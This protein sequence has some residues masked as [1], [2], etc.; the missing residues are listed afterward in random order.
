TL[1][2]PGSL[3]FVKPDRP[4]SLRN[5]LAWWEYRPGADWRHPQG[6]GSS[7]AGRDDHP[8]VHVAYEDAQAYASWCGKQ[9]PTE[10]EWEFAAR[11]G[12]EGKAYPW[13]DAANPEGWFPAKYKIAEAAWYSQHADLE[14][15]S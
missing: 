6:T 14:N 3:V 13:G 7:I 5:N 2:V 8:V 15:R 9:L 1:L 4:V 10:A 12:L 11:G